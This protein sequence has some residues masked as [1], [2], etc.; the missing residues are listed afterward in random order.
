MQT[1]VSGYEV[2]QESLN[3]GWSI[4]G[5]TMFFMVNCG[6]CW[7]PSESGRIRITSDP[8]PFLD[9]FLPVDW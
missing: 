7:D 6:P 8:L 3:N 5:H 9:F 1:T 4:S 2:V